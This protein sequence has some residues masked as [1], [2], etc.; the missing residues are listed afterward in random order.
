MTLIEDMSETQRQAWITLLVDATVFFV[1][2]K[3]MMTGL[4]INTLSAAGLSK[5]ILGL[6]IT[7]VIL[8][9]IIQSVFAARVRLEADQEDTSLKDERDLRIERKGATYG[10]WILAILLNIL[11]GHIVIQNG[12]DSIPEIAENHQSFFDYRN[13]SHLVFALI[14]ATFLG[15]IVKNIV[16]IISYR[17]GE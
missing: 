11:I 14:L 8:H 12:I 5:F 7:T 13:T 17:S 6:I 2:L 9:I 16:M 10:F 3:G 15:D 1:F 4:S